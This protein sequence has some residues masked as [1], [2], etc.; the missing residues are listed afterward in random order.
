MRGIF[1]VGLAA[2]TL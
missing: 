1:Y 2:S